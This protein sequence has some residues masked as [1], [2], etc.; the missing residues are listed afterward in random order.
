MLAVGGSEH[1][2]A[3]AAGTWARRAGA[4]AGAGRTVARVAAVGARDLV[5]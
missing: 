5:M 2:G 3:G 4:W 1:E